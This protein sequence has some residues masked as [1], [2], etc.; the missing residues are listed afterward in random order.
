MQVHNLLIAKHT[1]RLRPSLMD[2]CHLRCTP[3]QHGTCPPKSLVRRADWSD[4]APV[5]LE[6]RRVVSFVAGSRRPARPELKLTHL[7]PGPEFFNRYA[8]PT[9]FTVFCG[10]K[11]CSTFPVKP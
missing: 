3:F 5:Y 2:G 10:V 11:S 7:A 6:S 1:A 4:L 9:L 8:L